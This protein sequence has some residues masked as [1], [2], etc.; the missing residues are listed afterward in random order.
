MYSLPK[1]D[2]NID[3]SEVRVTLSLV[4]TYSIL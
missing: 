4:G 1:V 3:Y 2:L